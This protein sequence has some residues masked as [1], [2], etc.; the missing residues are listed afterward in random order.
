MCMMD[1][2]PRRYRPSAR[3]L[4]LASCL[5]GLG[6]CATT[7]GYRGSKLPEEQLATI[8]DI[9]LK[10]GHL[11]GRQRNVYLE[12]VDDKTVGGNV[13]GYPNKVFIVPGKHTIRVRFFDSQTDKRSISSAFMG[14]IVGGAIGGALMGAIAEQDRVPQSR[15]LSLTAAAGHD[16]T[17]KFDS[18][19]ANFAEMGI[20]IE[21]TVTGE[22]VGGIRDSFRA[23]CV[24]HNHGTASGYEEE[25]P[26][27]EW[28]LLSPSRIVK[29]YSRTR[30]E[31]IGRLNSYDGEIVT[32]SLM[33]G[34]DF[35]LFKSEIEKITAFLCD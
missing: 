22:V 35:P 2:E 23:Q 34:K 8:H 33:A 5:A 6:S 7:K 1:R 30:G 25:V 14:G 11:F 18:S 26:T 19:T 20:W 10:E 17:V 16:Y 31:L 3:V 29:V 15:R 13:R 21:D 12:K 9:R 27:E 4:L 28:S 32:I 24:D